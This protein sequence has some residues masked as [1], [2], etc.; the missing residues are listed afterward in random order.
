[1]QQCI[2]RTASKSG[3]PSRSRERLEFL[4]LLLLKQQPRNQHRCHLPAGRARIQ[5]NPRCPFDVLRRPVFR[6][7][8]GRREP[9]RARRFRYTRSGFPY[10]RSQLLQSRN[11]PSRKTTNKKKPR[12]LNLRLRFSEQSVIPG[13]GLNK[14]TGK[15]VP[16][17]TVKIRHIYY[18]ANTPIINLFRTR[19][20]PP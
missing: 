7:S 10:L 15:P 19:S 13:S 14:D 17:A 18:N 11:P 1:M 4:R 2:A 5:V 3:I 16:Q 6:V 12:S 20:S 8:T 9:L